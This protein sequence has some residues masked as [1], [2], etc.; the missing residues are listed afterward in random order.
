MSICPSTHWLA[1][2]SL[3]ERAMRTPVLFLSLAL[4]ACAPPSTSSVG[5]DAM[6]GWYMEHA[7]ART[8]LPCG[9]AGPL[10]ISDAG[11]LPARAREFGLEDDLPVY[12]RI[13]ALSR[14]GA[15]VVA[16]VDQFGSPTPVSDCAMT[17]V[18]MP[19]PPSPASPP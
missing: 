1:S 14:K 9:G 3:I 7:G 15:L 16:S 12:V 6:A 8:L 17:G 4:A 5:P 13:H 19:S 11:N 18:V 2:E 10:P